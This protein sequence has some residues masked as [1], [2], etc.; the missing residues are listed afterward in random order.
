MLDADADRSVFPTNPKPAA[1]S[2]TLEQSL[3]VVRSPPEEDKAV[4][5]CVLL[6]GRD[7]SWVASFAWFRAGRGCDSKFAQACTRSQGP[8]APLMVKGTLIATSAR[9]QVP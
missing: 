6:D 8:H 3:F 5:C 7:S 1:V 9:S 4:V 2:V